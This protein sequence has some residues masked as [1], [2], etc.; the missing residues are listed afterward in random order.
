MAA[1]V[2]H[3]KPLLIGQDAFRI[4]HIWQDHFRGNFWRAGP[5]L[6]A[7]ISALDIALWDLLGKALEVPTYQLLGRQDSRQSPL[8]R[9]T[10]AAIAPETFAQAA[11]ARVDEG[12]RGGAVR[13][14]DRSGRHPGTR[15]GGVR[16]R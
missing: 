11:K 13:F 1:A 15:A 9:P 8:L 12:L 6:T 4:E 14:A 5:V 16:T 2:E 10:L 7:T 3:Y